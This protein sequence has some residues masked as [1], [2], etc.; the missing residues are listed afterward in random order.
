M[1]RVA[2]LDWIR[3]VMQRFERPLV[4]FAAHIT[5]SQEQARDVVQDTFERLCCV[6]REQVELQLAAWLFRVCRN[7]ALDVSKKEGRMRPMSDEQREAR[8]H[9]ASSPASMAEARQELQRA[10]VALASLPDSQQEVVRLKIQ[11]GLSYREISEVTGH[12]V[13][14]VGVLLHT[15][16]T[17]IRQHLA[18]GRPS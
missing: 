1:N 12:T 13:S 4:R 7:R 3:R 14:N 11:A 2:E 10:M 6:D 9:A 16:L 8:P 15:A 5:G 18:E 17:T